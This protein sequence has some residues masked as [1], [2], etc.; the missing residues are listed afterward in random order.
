MIT[1]NYAPYADRQKDW[2]ESLSR[3][4]NDISHTDETE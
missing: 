2:A 1:L 3:N 4:A